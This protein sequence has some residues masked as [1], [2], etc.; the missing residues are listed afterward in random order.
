MFADRRKKIHD[1][2]IKTASN[3]QPSDLRS[4]A[5]RSLPGNQDNFSLL[6]SCIYI[7]RN[8]YFLEVLLVEPN[9]HCFIYLGFTAQVLKVCRTPCRSYSLPKMLSLDSMFEKL[10]IILI[11]TNKQV[12]RKI[13]YF[14]INKPDMPV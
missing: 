13:C 8:T 2:P 3:L 14:K 12:Y 9:G 4:N 11:V 5:Y 1:A 7:H 10:I 6:F